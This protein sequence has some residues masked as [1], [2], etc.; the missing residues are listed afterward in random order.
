M[1]IDKL[2]LIGFC[3]KMDINDP[4][5]TC[6]MPLPCAFHDDPRWMATKL[7]EDLRKRDALLKY[8]QEC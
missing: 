3:R 7:K 2:D 4:K 8:L 6:Y 5:K 1:V